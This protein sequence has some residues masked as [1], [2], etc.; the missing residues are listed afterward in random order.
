MN[1]RCVRDEVKGLASSVEV[2]EG[3]KE[4]IRDIWKVRSWEE[5]QG[6]VG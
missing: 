3:K 6:R 1:Q 4:R 5:K 2:R